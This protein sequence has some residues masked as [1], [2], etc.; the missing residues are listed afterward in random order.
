MTPAERQQRRRDR[1]KEA[2][3]AWGSTDDFRLELRRWI[4]SN[5]AFRFTKLTKYEIAELLDEMGQGFGLEYYRE[6]P[7]DCRKRDAVKRAQLHGLL[8]GLAAFCSDASGHRD[9]QVSDPT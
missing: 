3:P 1:I 4:D 8:G 5:M 2:Q 7:E 9:G 6:N